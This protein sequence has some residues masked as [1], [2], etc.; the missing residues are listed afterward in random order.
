VVV[1]PPFPIGL[2]IVLVAL[3]PRNMIVVGIDFPLR[4]VGRLARPPNIDLNLTARG[5]SR[6]KER[7]HHCER[8]KKL[9]HLSHIKP[10]SQRKFG[11]G[12]KITSCS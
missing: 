11:C 6:A 9:T 8:K 2:A 3:F 5:A 1:V 7:H 12:M 10:L 4:V